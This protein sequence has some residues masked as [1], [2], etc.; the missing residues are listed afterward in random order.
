MGSGW[1]AGLGWARGWGGLSELAGLDWA[2]GCWRGLEL[3]FSYTL[4]EKWKMQSN[5]KRNFMQLL[6]GQFL[7]GL[8]FEFRV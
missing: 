6:V 5:S 4:S 2:G 3:I 7:R 1:A 8:G